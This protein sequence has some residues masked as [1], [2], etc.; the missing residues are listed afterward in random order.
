MGAVVENKSGTRLVATGV[1]QQVET[2]QYLTF[3]LMGNTYALSIMNIKEIIQFG[4]LTTVPM[5]PSFVR[6]VINL[7]GRV[8]PV[9]D[10]AARFGLGLTSVARRTSIVLVELPQ[11]DD[12][13]QQLGIMVDAVNE[14][15]DIGA[16]DIEP[17]PSFGAQVR[18]DFIS[19]MAKQNGKFIVVLKLEQV[20][21][22]QEMAGIAQGLNE[23]DPASKSQNQ[24]D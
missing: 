2:A 1:A 13:I 21:S 7:R 24:I 3:M 17:P 19:G 5:M 20:L 10:L 4:E 22:M 8:V 16:K 18:P 12:E 23:A 9:I 14:V 6:G 11:A 15:V